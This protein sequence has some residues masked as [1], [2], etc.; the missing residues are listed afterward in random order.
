MKAV[1]KAS[2]LLTKQQTSHM[3]VIRSNW[4]ATG[5]AELPA[6]LSGP[7]DTIVM[8]YMFG[9]LEHFSPFGE[10]RLLGLLKAKLAPGG[11]FI[12]VGK[13]PLPYPNT[14][15]GLGRNKTTGPTTKRCQGPTLA[16]DFPNPSV[17]Q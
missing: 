16:R 8:D 7:F 11:V 10:H 17:D 9:A 4:L 12:V 15:G 6:A 2:K 1:L 14:Q 5:G 13:Q 3:R